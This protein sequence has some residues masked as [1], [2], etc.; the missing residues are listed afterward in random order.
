MTKKE[1]I[2]TEYIPKILNDVLNKIKCE[3]PTF[4]NDQYIELFISFHNQVKQKEDSL[5]ILN[6][7]ILNN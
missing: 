7:N 6:D 5:I 4:T 2:E 1:F 3:L